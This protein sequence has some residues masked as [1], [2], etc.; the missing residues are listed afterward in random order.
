MIV[1]VLFIM[2]VLEDGSLCLEFVVV[3]GTSSFYVGGD[4]AHRGVSRD[5]GFGL[6]LGFSEG[7]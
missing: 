4:W 5:E 1:T 3:R 2:F 6:R 7:T